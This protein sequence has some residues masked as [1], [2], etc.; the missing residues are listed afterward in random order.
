MDRIEGEAGGVNPDHLSF[1]DPLGQLGVFDLIAQ[2]DLVSFL[3]KLGD[4]RLGGE[5]GNATEDGRNIISGN[6]GY[7]IYFEDVS[8]GHLEGLFSP[9]WT[10][11]PVT[12]DKQSIR[13]R[14]AHT[15]GG[16]VHVMPRRS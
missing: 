13:C 8:G 7:G 3:Q 1:H 6:M 9:A 15:Q 10:A 2:G 11:C 12:A 16:P 4:V 5:I 14:N